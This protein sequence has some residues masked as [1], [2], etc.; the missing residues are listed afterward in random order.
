M[1]A[2]VL[3]GSRRVVREGDALVCRPGPAA[4]LGDFSAAIAPG[5]VVR[6]PAWSL[7]VSAV[8]GWDAGE[9]V[10]RGATETLLDADALAGPLG[11]RLPRR[12]DRVHVAG[13][14][15]RKLQDVFVDRKIP[16]EHR[17]GLAVLT[18]GDVVLWVPGVLR[19]SAARVGA[20]TR[21]VL[22]AR[23][24]SHDNVA[25]PLT[26]PCGSLAER[27]ERTERGRIE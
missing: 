15:T 23:L 10:H 18:A 14:G 12:G 27:G 19:S 21:R 4:I 26:K 3:P 9:G 7:E 20:D 6:G 8:R 13:V 22:E 5:D 17:A 2:I 24:L 16:R 11:V 25:L 1:G